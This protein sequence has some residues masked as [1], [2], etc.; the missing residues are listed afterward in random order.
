MPSIIEQKSIKNKN[1]PQFNFKIS[2]TNYKSDWILTYLVKIKFK[3]F[4][5]KYTRRVTRFQFKE[6]MKKRE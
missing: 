4:K 5:N 3:L 1:L 2:V 6:R